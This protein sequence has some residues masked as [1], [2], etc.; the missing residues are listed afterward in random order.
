MLISAI[1]PLNY[2]RSSNRPYGRVL[3]TE[4]C[5]VCRNGTASSSTL[6]LRLQGPHGQPA[7]ECH[8]PVGGL[9]GTAALPVS[10]GILRTA[11]L[12][13][14][15]GLWSGREKGRREVMHRLRNNACGAVATP[16]IYTLGVFAKR[17][18]RCIYRTWRTF[19]KRCQR[20]IYKTLHL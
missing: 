5:P 16:S 2:G 20:C 13:V 9:L 10:P 4:C 11:A 14:S 1:P 6:R 7:G 8:R 12:S 19:T 3:W 18:K 15:S 17:C